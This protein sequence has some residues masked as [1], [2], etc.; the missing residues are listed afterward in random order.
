[1]NMSSVVALAQREISDALKNRWFIVYSGAFVVLSVA[2]AM[3]VVNSA[4]YAG[5]SGFGR[6]AAGLINLVLFLAP[7]MGLTLGAQA[8]ATERE[9]GTLSY[10]L[11]QPISMLELFV[12]KFT[13]LALA[14]GAAIVFGFALSTLT[15]SYLSGGEG[16]DVFLRLTVLTVLLAWVSLALGYLISS[17]S[18]R[19]STALGIAIVVW[20]TLVLIGNLGL[21]GTSVVL[22]IDPDTL[23]AL[24][25]VNPLEVFRIA[26]IT[27][28]RDSMEL[29]GPSGLVARRWFGDGVTAVLTGILVAWLFVTLVL[30]YLVTKREE[31]K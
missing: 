30:A 10:L 22:D 6:T 4:G 8:I 5:I 18:R 16:I 29:L 2:L 24:T 27:L 9:Q 15:I 23:L 11:A 1:M 21:M 17:F 28:L 20:L 31:Q 3:M 25:L 19:T 13:G 14:I 7:L 12:A 26:A